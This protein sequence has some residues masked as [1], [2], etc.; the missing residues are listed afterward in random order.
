MK[1]K[2][3]TIKRD[4]LP[5]MRQLHAKSDDVLNSF[6]GIACEEHTQRQTDFGVIYLKPF[7]VVSDFENKTTY[8]NGKYSLI[9]L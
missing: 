2:V 4:A 5:F 7:K 9:L 8:N 3:N 6:P 1:V